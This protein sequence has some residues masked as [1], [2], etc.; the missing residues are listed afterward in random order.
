MT[1]A[2]AHHRAALE[3]LSVSSASA[4]CLLHDAALAAM[5]AVSLFAEGAPIR[6]ATMLE[7]FDLLVKMLVLPESPKLRDSLRHI[8]RA[9]SRMRTP[10]MPFTVRSEPELDTMIEQ[11]IDDAERVINAAPT[12][13]DPRA[14][15]KKTS[16]FKV[17]AT[18]TPMPLVGAGPCPRATET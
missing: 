1:V 2:E 17:V 10:R 4:I 3:L 14:R 6:P 16:P 12:A 13:M 9:G 8:N 7:E 15:Q 18:A 11:A 5:N